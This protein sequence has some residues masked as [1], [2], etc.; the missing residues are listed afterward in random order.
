MELNACQQEELEM[1]NEKLKKFSEF[2]DR[3]GVEKTRKLIKLQKENNPIKKLSM[4]LGINPEPY[5]RP[6]SSGILYKLGLNNVF[7]DPRSN[8]KKAL[9][10]LIAME[11]AKYENFKIIEGPIILKATFYLKEPKIIK[12]NILKQ[13]LKF[14]EILVPTTRPDIDNYIKPVMDSCNKIIYKDDSLIYNLNLIKVYAE[15]ENDC[16]IELEFKYRD[17][18]IMLR[19]KKEN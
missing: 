13:F 9:K 6:R 11:I 14:L 7:Y 5:S 4:T 18:P 10:K 2:Q 12:N 3:I 15:D 19:Y 16:R 8:Y 17:K 1:A